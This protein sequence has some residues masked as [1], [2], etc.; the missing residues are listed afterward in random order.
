MGEGGG[1]GGGYHVLHEPSSLN[2]K[3]KELWS[4]VLKKLFA[5]YIGIGIELGVVKQIVDYM[6]EQEDFQDLSVI[7]DS[8]NVLEDKVKKVIGKL[9]DITLIEKGSVITRI[10]GRPP[11]SDP[12]FRLNALG[13]DFLE[14]IL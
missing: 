13:K 2:D 6:N 14:Y 11:R 5:K 3:V 7:A 9:E 10:K 1:D 4:P 12:S 8:C